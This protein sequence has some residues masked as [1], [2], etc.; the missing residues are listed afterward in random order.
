VDLGDAG[1]ESEDR[2]G[3]RGG[4]FLAGQSQDIG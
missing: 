4:V 1:L 3:A 2:F